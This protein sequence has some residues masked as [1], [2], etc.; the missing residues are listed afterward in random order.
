MSKY[1]KGQKKSY[2]INCTDVRISKENLNC[3]I[4]RLLLNACPCYLSGNEIANRLKVSRVAIWS[5]IAKLRSEGF[6]IEATQNKGYRIATEPTLINESFLK[7]WLQ[8]LKTECSIFVLEKLDSTNS[9]AERMLANET[10]A[11]FAIIANKQTSGRGR[12]GKDWHSPASGNIYLS[13]AF[14]PNI[15]AV[16]LRKFTLL[17]GISICKY[18]R[19]A[20]NN[21]EIMLKWPN[22]IIC[23]GKKLGGMLTEAK[24]DCENIRSLVF[25]LGLNVNTKKS[26]F[27]KSLQDVVTSIYHIQ[28]KYT[29]VH[30]LT[31]NIVKIILK[32]YHEC[33][34][35]VDDVEF[36][37]RWNEL[38]SQFGKII[39][40]ISGKK[41]INGKAIGI[42]P[43]G[44]LIVK[45]KNG[46][47]KIIHSGEIITT[48]NEL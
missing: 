42:D 8:K 11:P 21:N 28:E 47:K 30:Q 14:K 27:P 6:C 40:I 34:K 38:D 3:T 45:L 44:G 7:A 29:R 36:V 13:L 20:T 12:I 33:I 2:K 25:G 22:D 41:E 15:H 31:A 4:L 1:P 43:Y 24:V 19:K 16:R 37:N 35:G 39:H 32:S 5:R 46:H 17:Q 48:K 9:E 23:N 26:S 10:K 18:L